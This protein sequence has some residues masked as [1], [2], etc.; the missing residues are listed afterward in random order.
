LAN[1]ADPAAIAHGAR[2]C[3]DRCNPA[4]ASVSWDH[5]PG[6]RLSRFPAPGGPGPPRPRSGPVRC[7]DR[8]RA[9]PRLVRAAI[10]ERQQDDLTAPTA[11]F[12]HVR[13]LARSWTVYFVAQFTIHDR[14]V[15][16]ATQPVSWRPSSNTVGCCWRKKTRDATRGGVNGPALP[17]HPPEG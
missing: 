11:A 2:G 5:R 3:H 14:S 7:A 6:P 4:V 8:L 16:S 17:G 12:Q 1:P 13:R 9:R 10:G 15:I